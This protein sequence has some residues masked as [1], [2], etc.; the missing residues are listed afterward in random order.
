MFFPP[1]IS[2]EMFLIDKFVATL[3]DFPWESIS[4]WKIEKEQRKKN[5]KKETRLQHDGQT[6]HAILFPEDAFLSPATRTT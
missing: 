5:S 6:M 3:T 2:W 1:Q 4:R